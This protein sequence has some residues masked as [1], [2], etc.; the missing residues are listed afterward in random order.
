MQEWLREKC[1]NV[2]EW[3]SQSRDMEP[4][5]T[6]LERP[7]NSCAATLPIQPKP[8]KICRVEWEKLPKYRCSKL[9]VSY[10]RKLEVVI[11][12]KGASTKY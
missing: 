2:L 8:A 5:L 9:V 6:S 7:E 4:N 12:T 10:P 1:L 3:P 11:A